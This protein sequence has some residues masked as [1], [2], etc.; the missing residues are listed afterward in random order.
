M[1]GIVAFVMTMSFYA[2]VAL[3]ILMG[4]QWA[5]LPLARGA[6]ALVSGPQL[7]GVRGRA[8]GVVAVVGALVV[9]L[10]GFVP[11]PLRSVAEGVVWIPEEAFVR[12][13]SEGFVER[14][15]AAPGTRVRRGDLLVVS[16]DP[17]L[18]ARVTTLTARRRELEARYREQRVTD[19]VK[20]EIVREELA[21]VQAELARA[22]ERRTALAVHSATTG[23]LV[24]PDPQSLPGRFVKKGE[25][26][27]YVVD[28][29]SLT[30][31]TV[32]PQTAIDLVRARTE[33][34]HVRLAE[35]LA[36]ARPAVLQR[37]VP[38]A[39]E[40]LPSPALGSQGGGAVGVD[41]RDPEG[42]T[43]VGKV[44]QVDLT[45]PVPDGLV[46]LGGRVYVRFDHG[47][48]PLAAQWYRQLRQ[49]FLARFD[50]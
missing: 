10:V 22:E 20:A 16:R 24:V 5:V 6:R 26:L 29:E 39:T 32:V 1:V 34:I 35:R 12:A 23:T 9:G 21:Y 2:G 33:A 14:I 11:V 17:A 41:P 44:F 45:L 50:V 42:R 37:E 8:F 43:A 30:V 13:E 47:N 48:E 4:V 3:G 25:L 38:G 49:L 19:A 27:A 28:L 7:R 40:K 18:D 15:V 31:R 36:E 46:N